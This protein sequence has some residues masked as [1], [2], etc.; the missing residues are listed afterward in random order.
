MERE[1]VGPQFAEHEILKKYL[2]SG[3]KRLNT[4]IYTSEDRQKEKTEQKKRLEKIKK[5]E[6]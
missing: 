2:T 5:K 6:S 4:D 1:K 3:F